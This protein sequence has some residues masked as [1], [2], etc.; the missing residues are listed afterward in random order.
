MI[1]ASKTIDCFNSICQ[2]F[3][4][5]VI[6]TGDSRESQ[7]GDRLPD[8]PPAAG[9]PGQAQGRGAQR[10]DHDLER[11]RHHRHL[12]GRLRPGATTIRVCELC[13]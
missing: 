2:L 7:R 12:R 4:D 3:A 6:I 8:P 11:L 10:E 13:S 1:R 5:G 9:D